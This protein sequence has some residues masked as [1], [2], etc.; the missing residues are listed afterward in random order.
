M[1]REA[2][3]GALTALNLVLLLGIGVTQI[4]PATAQDDFGIVRGSAFELVDEAGRVRA[5]LTIQPP[6]EGASETVLLRLIQPNGQ[7][8]AKISASATGAGLSFVGGDDQSYL[9]LEAD[10][11]ETALRMVEG[12][13]E[14]LVLP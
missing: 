13:G 10:G 3:L 6:A 9:I 5:S 1:K 4:L 8:A 7:P 2:M 14:Q 12:G 11:P